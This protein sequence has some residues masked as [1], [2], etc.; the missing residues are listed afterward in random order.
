MLFFIAGITGNV[1]GATARHLLKDGHSLRA[2]VRDATKAKP[3]ADQGVELVKGDWNDTASLTRALT[4]VDGAYLMMPPT[5]TPSRDFREAKAVIASYQQAIREARPKKLV[6]LSSF[7]SEQT[8]GIGLITSTHL[9]EEG[10]GNL[11]IPTAVMRPGGFFEN[12]TAQVAPTRQ[13][14]TLYSF[15]QPVE[16]KLLMTATADIGAEAAKLL[17]SE[18]TGKRIVEIGTEYSPADIAATM[19]EVFGQPITA[20]AVP[21]DHWSGVLQQFGLPAEHTWAYEEMIEAIN[22]GHIHHNVPGTEP[23]PGTITPTQFFQGL[24]R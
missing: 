14:G 21:R 13:S 5:Q 8:S 19:T 17:T 11:G 18:F 16:R 1:G 15:Y 7:G 20:Q 24:N 6:L 2:L 22:S 23:V 4:G 10:V 12:Y 9:L 3:W